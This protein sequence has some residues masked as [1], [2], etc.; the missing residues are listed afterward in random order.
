MYGKNDATKVLTIRVSE[1][2][3]QQL[4]AIIDNRRYHWPRVTM[5]SKA[6]EMIAYCLRNELERFKRE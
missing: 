6:R 3:Y 1:A 5:S 2:E 4:K